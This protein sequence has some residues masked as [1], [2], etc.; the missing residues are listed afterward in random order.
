MEAER[1]GIAQDIHDH[2]GA[3]LTEIAVLASTGQQPDLRE[4][5]VG[6]L[7]QAIAG[8]AKELI[9]AL[10][11]IVWALDPRD[12]SLQLVGDYLSD[13]AKDYLSSFG[14][15]TGLMFR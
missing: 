7:F 9:S 1:S 15:P 3:S 10:D 14:M 12:N 5:S 13:F 4:Q 6:T 11:I 8:K 2:L